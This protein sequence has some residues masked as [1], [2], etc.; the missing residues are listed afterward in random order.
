MARESTPSCAGCA[1]RDETIAWL[2]EKVLE[3]LQIVASQEARIRSLEAQLKQTSRNSHRPPSSDPPGTAKPE[4]KRSSRKPGGQPG[5]EGKTRELLPAEQVD[6]FVP[7]FPD[8]CGHCGERLPP[9]EGDPSPVRHQVTEIPPVKPE[10]TEYQLH[11]VSCPWCGELTRAVLSDGVPTVAFGPRL[12]A[13]VAVLT[14]AYRLSKRNVAQILED[15][16]G[17][18]VALGSVANLERATSQA[19]ADPVEEVREHVKEVEVVHADETSW[20]QRRKKAWL[21]TAV[22][23]SAAVFLIRGSR[24]RKVAEE[25]LGAEPGIVV[26]D[27]YSAYGWIP[28][29]DRQA[30]W[31]HLKRNFQKIADARGYRDGMR[32]PVPLSH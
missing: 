11:A 20:R 10:V 28:V 9:G 21:W 5:H 12:T 7:V 29:R 30:C 15:L 25:L 2:Q 1:A 13:V 4:R 26:S 31:S 32:R 16:F 17:V 3:L 8:R 19:L 14:G 27:R 23:A 6:H 24:G 22:T 18:K